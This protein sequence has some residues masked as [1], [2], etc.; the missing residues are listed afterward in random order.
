MVQE[1]RPGDRHTMQLAP[2][3]G[4]RLDHRD[5]VLSVHSAAVSSAGSTFISARPLPSGDQLSDLVLSSGF[6][7]THAVCKPL[8]LCGILVRRVCPSG[9][10]AALQ[11]GN[12]W[13]LSVSTR[14]GQARTKR[15]M[16]QLASK[17]DCTWHHYWREV[18]FRSCGRLQKCRRGS[19]PKKG[20]SN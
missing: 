5:M 17:A 4:R 9:R 6:P 19:S 16:S 3:S 15:L 13:W 10:T 8:P 18:S 12:Q 20:C 2:A 11:H 1:C 14:L 7:Q